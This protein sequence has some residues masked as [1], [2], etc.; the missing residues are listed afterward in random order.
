MSFFLTIRE[1]STP[2]ESYPIFATADPFIIE[3]VAH[4]LI[5][6]LRKDHGSDRVVTLA[7]KR[8]N[9]EKTAE[10]FTGDIKERTD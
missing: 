7:T 4:N 10:D 6:R 8:K 1:G 5:T 9:H 2:D 3:M